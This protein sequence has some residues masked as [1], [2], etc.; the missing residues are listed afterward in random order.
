MESS[1][2]LR[3]DDFK[4][5]LPFANKFPVQDTGYIDFM[6]SSGDGFYFNNSLHIYGTS[7]KFLHHDIYYRNE[8]IHRL[9]KAFIDSETISFGE[10]L[11]GNQFVFYSNGIGLLSIET[12]EV[13]FI[14]QNFI[15]WLNEVENSLDYY[16]GESLMLEWIEQNEMSLDERLTPKVPFVLGGAYEIENLYR[17]KISSVLEFNADLAAQIRDLPDGATINLKIVE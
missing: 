13:E 15:Q 16:S 5:E 17:A 2:F 12:G 8:L 6:M 10:D 7:N 3:K 14:A 4:S 11:F 1:K 9:F